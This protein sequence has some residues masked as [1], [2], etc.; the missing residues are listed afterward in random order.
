MPVTFCFV[1]TLYCTVRLSQ[2]PTYR[3][4]IIT[5]LCL[6]AGLLCK[7]TMIFIYP[8]LLGMCIIQG[9][10]R[11]LLPYLG[12][13]V[14]V[15]GSVLAVWL[16]YTAAVGIL[17]AQRDTLASHTRFASMT[18]GGL[19]WK[20]GTSLLGLPSGL[21]TYSL[22]LLVVGGR[23]LLQRK[24]QADLLVLLWI[25]A[26]FVPLV[27]TLPGPRYFLP[28]FPALALMMACGLGR[29][30]EAAGRLI[31]VAL[32][33]CGGALYLFVDWYRQVHSLFV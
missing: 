28:A 16:G 3:L 19:R 5:G 15:S 11:R 25:G 20:V 30:G 13:V 21:G 27:L 32:L 2:A 7:Y 9:A 24:S 31:L 22:P 23:R 4:A 26:V 29:V 6:G 14:L 1:L 33:Y 12:V 10:L 17:T 8:L 18:N